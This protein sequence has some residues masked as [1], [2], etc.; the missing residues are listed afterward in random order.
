MPR[1]GSGVYTLPPGINPV[2]TQTLITSQWANTTMTDIANAL[3]QSVSR[4]GQSPMTGNLNMANFQVTN[5]GTPTTAGSAVSLSYVQTGAQFRLANVSGVNQLTASLAGGATSFTLGQLVELIPASTNTGPVTLNV[6]GAGYVPVVSSLG[7]PLG[8]TSLVAGGLYLLGWDGAQWRIVTAPNQATFVQSA[9]SGWDRPVGGTYPPITRVN[10]NTVAVPAGAGRIIAPSTRDTSGVTEVTWVAQN[11]ALTN[12]PNAW[13]TTLAVN[14]SG[15]IVQ[16]VGLIQS[17]WARQYIILGTVAHI[18]GQ[19]DGVVNSPSIFGDAA[20][21]AFDLAVLFH[22]TIT[23][24]GQV[25]ASANPV[26]LDVKA[27]RM[28]LAGGNASAPNQPN[29]IDFAD[30]INITLYPS[31]ATNVVAA[32]TQAVPVSQ[33]DPGGAGTVTNIPVPLSQ[34]VIHRLFLMAG[35]YVLCYGQ[36]LY[37]DLN[38]AIQNINADNATFKPPAKLVG[39]SLFAYLCATGNSTNLND[40]IGGRIVGANAVSAAGG[41]GG[42]GVTEAPLDGNAYARLNGAWWRSIFLDPN[43]NAQLGNNAKADGIS[44]SLNAQAATNR[45]LNFQSSGV[46]RFSMIVDNT[47]EPGA[48]AG[49]NITFNRY[50]DNGAFLEAYLSVN[51]A[52]G[53]VAFGNGAINFGNG[54][55]TFG[56]GTKTFGT[57]ATSFAANVSF[58]GNI[59]VAGSLTGNVTFSGPVSLATAYGYFGVPD[60]PANPATAP[61]SWT[62]AKSWGMWLAQNVEY[63]TAAWH[64]QNTTNNPC[65]L[66]LT[67]A[68]GL[69]FLNAPVPATVGAVVPLTARFTVDVNGN[70]TCTQM[71]TNQ[72]FISSSANIIMSPTGAGTCYLRPNGAGSGTGQTVVDSNGRLSINANAIPIL[73][74]ND[75]SGTG[76]M[77]LFSGGG[78]SYPNKYLRAQNSSFQVING[79]NT[80]VM[81]QFNDFGSAMNLTVA[82]TIQPS[83]DNAGVCGTSGARWQTVF[84]VSGT[85][86]TC[87]VRE[88]N[89]TGPNPLGLDFVN[90]IPV[91]CFKYKVGHNDTAPLVDAN[92]EAILDANG[93]FQ[94]VVTPVPG[95]RTHVTGMAQDIQAQLVAA[96]LDPSNMAMWSLDDPVNPDSRQGLRPDQLMWVLWTAVQQLSGQVKELK[97]LLNV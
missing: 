25:Q 29:F 66:G 42:G 9:T 62:S 37:P 2:V 20:Y 64:A 78:G 7:L 87:D 95:V 81:A 22:N 61:A 13:A 68:G 83:A 94:T 31:T 18:D 56:T 53:A 82:N 60:T 73:S 86:N 23:A 44:L 79:S 77:L 21:Q 91:S 48:N 1:N 80:Y 11:V 84:A 39:A 46:N 6:N 74:L 92:G 32:A 38:T 51:R 17:Q 5:L 16:L 43:Y 8:N 70:A 30:Q 49:G 67:P 54:N 85:I 88:K 69:S 93:N 90:A 75:S 71:T 52:T 10:A 45:Q 19:I 97:A 96:G 3:T 65:V 55:L 4:D 33:Y 40:G 63:S 41:G 12:I 27:G 50:A 26:H 36:T 72:S 28:W 34:A 15:A 24:G 76:A 47:A 57:G 35:Q 14:A 59:S 89:I 58:L